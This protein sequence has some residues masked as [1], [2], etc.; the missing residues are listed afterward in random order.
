MVD[1]QRGMEQ[2]LSHGGLEDGAHVDRD[3]EHL[4]PSGCLTLGEPAGDGGD[5]TAFDLAEQPLIPGQVHEADKSPVA[6]GRPGAGGLLRY[7]AGP[8]AAHLVNAQHDDRS[9]LGG[10]HPRACSVNVADTTG[11][12]RPRQP[13]VSR[14]LHHRPPT[15]TGGLA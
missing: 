15:V 12:E 13:M 6:C 2:C 10:Q 5:G 14:R 1:Y 8:T 9:G 11:H 3:E 4:S 7:P